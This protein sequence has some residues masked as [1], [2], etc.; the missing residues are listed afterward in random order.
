M[1]VGPLVTL[2]VRIVMGN[3]PFGIVVRK[4]TYRLALGL[5]GTSLVLV[6]VTCLLVR[7]VTPSKKNLGRRTLCLILVVKIGLRFV[8]KI[9]NNGRRFVI[10]RDGIISPL[11]RIL[12]FVRWLIRRPIIVVELL[13]LV[14]M[15]KFLR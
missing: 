5:V 12:L 3:I 7:L 14:P 10:L 4:Y 2:F 11:G 6:N 15:E 8:G 1:I 9:V 13:V